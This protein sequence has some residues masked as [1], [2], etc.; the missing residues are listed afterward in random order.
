[1]TG[2][3][4]KDERQ[5]DLTLKSLFR[6]ISMLL[7]LSPKLR[8]LRLLSVS[9]KWFRLTK[10][11]ILKY[12]F[13]YNVLSAV[14]SP[15]DVVA[16][17]GS[18]Q[19]GLAIF[20]ANLVGPHGHV[21]AFE[22]IP[23]TFETLSMNISAIHL[24]NRVTLNNVALSDERGRTVVN[25]PSSGT[26]GA[27]LT[28]HNFGQFWSHEGVTSLRCETETLDN[29]LRDNF[30]RSIDFVKIDVEG[31]EMLVLRGMGETLSA[32]IPPALML[33]IFPPFLGDFG[34][35]VE[36]LFLL[37]HSHRYVIYYIGKTSLVECPTAQEALE[38]IS[39]P[40]GVDFLCV[41][42]EKLQELSWKL[43]WLRTP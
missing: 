2:G 6:R 39:F 18:H 43:P 38:L 7:V 16:D 28:L 24:N 12:N 32:R 9:P 5:R 1:M 26:Q 8:Y 17:I 4:K 37:L 14:I 25:I 41:A 42:P 20:F 27:S 10:M 34:F 13:R 15:S 31:A 19:G 23:S 11:Y 3:H 33:E 30:I 35:N 36:D 40:D 21:H 22:P 29:Y